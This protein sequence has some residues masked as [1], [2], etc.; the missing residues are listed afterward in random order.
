MLRKT[1]LLIIILN[2]AATSF[3][4]MS[5]GQNVQALLFKV[6]KSEPKLVD[7]IQET[8]RWY[9]VTPRA[10]AIS[11]TLY[12][13]LQNAFFQDAEAACKFYGQKYLI[14]WRLLLAKS[15]RESFWGAS[16]LSNR[17][18]NYFG[19]RRTNKDWACDSFFFCEVVMR[20]DPEP[21]AFAIFED[22][23]SSLWMFIHTIY[24]D[25]F[26]QR[27]PD[28]GIRVVPAIRAERDMSIRYWELSDYD[29][30]FPKQLPG[31]IYTN[32]EIMY[33][34]SGHAINN[35][36]VNCDMQTDINWIGKVERTE[37]RVRRLTRR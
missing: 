32:Q 26:L 1:I 16:Y 14:D 33:T 24:S 31:N 34:W 27:L 2:S 12:D 35:L 28:A 19:I 11:E 8:G 17:A 6:S 10:E 25:H 4:Q 21:A 30:N 15:A 7:Y 22:F 36:C 20:N 3:A 5:S 37:Q 9:L 23:E 29:L 13:Q 18:F